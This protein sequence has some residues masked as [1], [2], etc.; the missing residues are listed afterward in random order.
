VTTQQYSITFKFLYGSL[1][2]SPLYL[3]KLCKQYIISE[4]DSCVL[5]NDKLTVVCYRGN[6]T[7]KSINI[8]ASRI[9]CE[10]MSQC[11]DQFK[12]RMSNRRWHSHQPPIT[13]RCKRFPSGPA[14][15]LRITFRLPEPG[16]T[17]EGSLVR[18]VRL[19][20]AFRAF[21]VA[22]LKELWTRLRHGNLPRSRSIKRYQVDF[23]ARK[24]INS[25]CHSASLSE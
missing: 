2:F 22:T 7:S 24:A 12:P 25:I 5:F 20:A 16:P 10:R 15:L 8:R 14:T 4:P 11:S 19:K 21:S 6:Y 18:A 17:R 13:L 9:D 3:T 1:T 23:A